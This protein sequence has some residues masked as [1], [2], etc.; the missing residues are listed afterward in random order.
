LLTVLALTKSIQKNKQQVDSGE[1]KNKRAVYCRQPFG[2]FTYRRLA[3][4]ARSPLESRGAQVDRL[5][6][7]DLSPQA[8][9]LADFEYPSIFL[10]TVL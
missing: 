6:F 8:L 10:S 9:L 3:E 5:K 4:T 7:R 2:A 1:K